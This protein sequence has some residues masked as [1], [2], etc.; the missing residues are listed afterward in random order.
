MHAIDFLDAH[1]L[2][3]NSLVIWMIINA[4]A[5]KFMSRGEGAPGQPLSASDEM[6]AT[7]TQHA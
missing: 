6:S 3:L 2:L 7:I 5:V 1:R 4:Q